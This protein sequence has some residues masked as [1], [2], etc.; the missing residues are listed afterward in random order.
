MTVLENYTRADLVEVQEGNKAALTRVIERIEQKQQARAQATASPE[1][2][3]SETVMEWY[4]RVRDREDERPSYQELIQKI[5]LEHSLSISKLAHLML[6][7]VGRLKEYD[8][9]DQVELRFVVMHH[10]NIRQYMA[11]L[12][13]LHPIAN[14]DDIG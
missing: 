8:A 3:T 11:D 7:Q 10:E 2:D 12:L 13:S 4:N 5:I 9:G 14:H 6:V 1:E